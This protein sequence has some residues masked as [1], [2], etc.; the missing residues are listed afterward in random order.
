MYW[1]DKCED[2]TPAWYQADRKAYCCM[3]KNAVIECGEYIRIL[4]GNMADL[5]DACSQKQEIIDANKGL[6]A[7]LEAEL[8]KNLPALAGIRQHGLTMTRKRIGFMCG[9]D[10]NIE[11]EGRD[12]TI[13]ASLDLLEEA[14]TCL[15]ECGI[16]KVAIEE[17]NEE[18]N[19]G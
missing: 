10:F 7:E 1:C 11:V 16:V 14:K 3:C 19:D 2:T 5:R 15:D 8:K 4:R 9:T 13:Y 17:I 18:Q 6:V 12:A